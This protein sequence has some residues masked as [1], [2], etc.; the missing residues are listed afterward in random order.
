MICLYG[1]S[2]CWFWR[3]YDVRLLE[4]VFGHSAGSG[5]TLQEA[6]PAFRFP[7]IDSIEGFGRIP[8]YAVLQKLDG[9]GR[10]PED[11]LHVLVPRSRKANKSRGV[12]AHSMV[13]DPPEGSLLRCGKSL[14]VSSPELTLVQMAS[15]L[16]FFEC[17]LLAY[18]FCG[19]YSLRP[20]LESGLLMRHPLT[21]VEALSS[22]LGKA[23]GLTGASALKRLLPF[24]ADGSGSPRESA[25]VLIFCLP[26]R[27]GGFGLP[28]PKMNLNV[29]L[30][31]GA[32]LLWGKENAFDLVWEKAKVV[33]E[34]DG[35]LGH[36]S[37]LQRDRDQRRREALAA[38]GYAVFVLNKRRLES[39][40]D[41][42]AVVKAVATRLGHRLRFDEGFR[43][44]HLELRSAVLGVR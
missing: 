31:A 29:D 11:P 30:G 25:A 10:N 40:S 22:F 7:S 24:V 21:S 12:V 5:P 16:S 1:T 39:I 17:L 15:D 4:H 34:Y 6:F 14:Y 41:T 38:S 43:G 3:R 18:E 8:D 44:R 37:D 42:Y 19:C 36:S 20:D 35:S 27:Y 28:L 23:Q 2:A 32:S 26:K 13:K 33:L 9:L